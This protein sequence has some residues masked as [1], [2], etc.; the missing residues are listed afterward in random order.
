M[1]PNHF[2]AYDKSMTK[3]QIAEAQ[4]MADAR[5][6]ARYDLWNPRSTSK[7]YRRGYSHGHTLAATGR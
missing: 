7:A 1:T 3:T 5:E 2:N 6:D 4:G